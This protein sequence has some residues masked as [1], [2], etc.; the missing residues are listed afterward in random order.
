MD[1]WIILFL[2]ALYLAAS[3]PITILIGKMMSF[4]LG[5]PRK[6]DEID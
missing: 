2:F 3:V 1:L 4:G 5:E 6:N